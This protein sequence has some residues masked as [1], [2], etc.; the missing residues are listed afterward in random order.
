MLLGCL[1]M[2]NENISHEKWLEIFGGSWKMIMALIP[3]RCSGSTSVLCFWG[4]QNKN[5][6]IKMKHPRYNIRTNPYKCKE[7]PH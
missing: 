1:V 6:T 4:G 3:E 5:T 2:H 7:N